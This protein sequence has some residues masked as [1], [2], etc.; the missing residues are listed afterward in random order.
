MIELKVAEIR[1]AGTETPP[2]VVLAE[3][4]GDERLLPIWMTHGGAAAIL[5][6]TEEPDTRRPSIHD[7]AGL[8]LT[9][10]A[11]SE[12][13]GVDIVG[14]EE[15]QFFAELVFP[16]R[17]LPARPSDA[18]A[19]ALRVGCPI[20]CS[21]A[22]MDAHS[23]AAHGVAGPQTGQAEAEVE[24]FLEFLDSVTPDDFTGEEKP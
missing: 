15:G 2:V 23:V 19:L 14:S 10:L 21:P 24:R 20:Q 13:T 22:V 1:V 4:G 12:L 16:D 5:G 11:E 8:I 18:I 9:E 3:V 17:R 7:L 6:A